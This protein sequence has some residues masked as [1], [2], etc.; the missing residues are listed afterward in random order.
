MPPTIILTVGS[1]PELDFVEVELAPPVL[2]QAARVN[3]SAP[4]ATTATMLCF[5]MVVLF[6]FVIPGFRASIGGRERR[7]VEDSLRSPGTLID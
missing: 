3:A 2:L 6:P 1:G 5:F 4:A 7:N